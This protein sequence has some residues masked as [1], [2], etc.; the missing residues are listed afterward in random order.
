ML[1]RTATGLLDWSKAISELN[2]S[3]TATPSQYTELSRVLSV[4]RSEIQPRVRAT[5]IHSFGSCSNGLWTRSSDVDLTM[6]VPRCNNKLKIVNKLRI[7][8]E[9]IYK[10]QKLTGEME[11]VENARIP[12]LKLHMPLSE[13]G[14]LDLSVNNISGVENSLLVKFWS[15]THP[16]FIP[17]ARAIKFWA[18]QRGIND[19]SK[20][21]LSTYTLLLMVVHILQRHQLVPRFEEYCHKVILADEFDEL[22]GRERRLPFDMHFRIKDTN[23]EPVDMKRLFSEFFN[24]FGNSD[25]SHGIEILDG[26]VVSQ[27]TLSGALVVRCPLTGK[28]VNVLSNSNWKVIHAEFAR[29][30]ALVELNSDFDEITRTIDT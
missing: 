1:R 14:E 4:L 6:I 17:L 2:A 5:A 20:G 3:V 7:V 19:R 15:E 13:I 28:D 18:K 9:Y 26:E 30:K 11:L 29:A 10:I 22:N 21:T 27:P 12:V 24:F 16:H 8:R 25:L 23:S